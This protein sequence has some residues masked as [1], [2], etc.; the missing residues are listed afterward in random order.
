MVLAPLAVLMFVMGIAPM[1]WLPVIE[2]GV[3]PQV[4]RLRLLQKAQQT[5]LRMTDISDSKFLAQMQHGEV[6]R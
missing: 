2:M 4:L 3:Q 6:S 5:S 1:G